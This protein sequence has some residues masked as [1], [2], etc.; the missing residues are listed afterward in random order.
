[1][2]SSIL[3][4]SPPAGPRRIIQT[5]SLPGSPKAARST[6]LVLTEDYVTPDFN[7]PKGTIAVTS[8]DGLTIIAVYLASMGQVASVTLPPG[9][10]ITLGPEITIKSPFPV[11]VANFQTMPDTVLAISSRYGTIDTLTLLADSVINYGIP[12]PGG[13]TISYLAGQ[14]FVVRLSKSTS[15]W[16]FPVDAGRLVCFD[17]DG[18][19]NLPLA[20]NINWKSR[21]LHAGFFLLVTQAG[22]LVSAAINRPVSV[23]AATYFKPAS[24]SN[25]SYNALRFWPPGNVR[26][27]WL[28]TS[29]RFGATEF[30]VSDI[31]FRENRTVQFGTLQDDTVIDGI[32]CLGG[33]QIWFNENGKPVSFTVSSTWTIGT[34][35]LTRGQRFNGRF[36]LRD[37]IIL[38]DPGTLSDAINELQT[39]YL[40]ELIQK[41]LKSSSKFPFGRMGT[42]IIHDVL[43][44]FNASDYIAT[45][46]E[47]AIPELFTNPPFADCDGNISANTVFGWSITYS[48]HKTRVNLWIAQLS[49]V[50][51]HHFCPGTSTLQAAGQIWSWIRG[52]DYTIGGR[53]TLFANKFVQKAEISKEIE[54]KMIAQI[55]ALLPTDKR[56]AVVDPV[57]LQIS[58]VYINDAALMVE[59]TYD[60]TLQ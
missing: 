50:I 20:Q 39:N 24:W 29:T 35:T 46:Q 2:A 51:S 52:I 25:E 12:V 40:E 16:G 41:L 19:A 8:D 38:M 3:A 37:T 7:L 33:T 13:S 47:L 54:K 44:D 14:L 11:T 4:G 21:Q 49:G 55:S 28:A 53:A 1:M 18:T 60:A 36:S 32:P 48:G 10:Y 57:S 59:F 31:Q 30:A 23:G 45:H 42:P 26:E 27:G 43:A 15:V 58:R 9:T 56:S 34:T 6:K 17:K 22:D 5:S